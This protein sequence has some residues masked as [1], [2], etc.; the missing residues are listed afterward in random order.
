MSNC[1][2]R[3]NPGSGLNRQLDIPL[4]VWNHWL[5]TSHLPA[6]LIAPNHAA[7]WPACP[8]FPSTHTSLLAPP[9]WADLPQLPFPPGLIA[10]N[11]PHNSLFT[12]NFPPCWPAHPQLPSLPGFLLPTVPPA[13]LIISICHPLLA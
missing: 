8:Q 3:P 7:C 11:C 13:S 9:C 4:S 1:R 10:P 5:L 2:V 6:C 12:P